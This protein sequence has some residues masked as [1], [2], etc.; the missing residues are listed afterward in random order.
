MTK[1]NITA[2]FFALALA[3]Q[4]SATTANASSTVEDIPNL[5]KMNDNLYRGGRVTAAGMKQL[6][7]MGVTTIINIEN[8]ATAIKTDKKF[9]DANGLRFITIPFDTWS[10]P[11]DAKVDGVLKLLQDRSLG[12]IY[13]H[14]K[15]GRDRTG[16]IMGL[17]RVE[18]DGWTPKAAYKE[19][20]DRGFRSIIWTLDGYYKRRTHY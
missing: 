14:C 17:Y 10:T 3:L 4:F 20:N 7:K 9:A 18:V 1:Q 12:P 8:D 13:L 5:F 19:M 6:K 2:F 11:S 16:L 15:H